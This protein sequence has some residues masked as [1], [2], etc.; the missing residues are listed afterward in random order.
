MNNKFNKVFPSF[1]LFNKEFAP[2][3]CLINIFS[4]C[5]SFH[6]SSQS[7]KCL[8]V[9]IQA[10]DNIALTSSS[11]P[12]IA[13]MVA[14]TSIKNQVAT[15]ISHIHIH[16]KQVIKIIHHAVNVTTTEAEL[17]AIKCGRN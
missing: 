17:F 10:L 12:S 9:Y 11:D 4:S 1:H 6:I 7:D 3:Y 13:L 16:N 15:S 8:N 2:G 5:F 14:D